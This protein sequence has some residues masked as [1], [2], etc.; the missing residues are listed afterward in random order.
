MLTSS[1]IQ[2]VVLTAS[3]VVIGTAPLLGDGVAI[4]PE[5]MAAY[6]ATLLAASLAV[7]GFLL[8]LAWRRFRWWSLPLD[9]LIL[10]VALFLVGQTVDDCLSQ[11]APS[12]REGFRYRGGFGLCTTNVKGT[13]PGKGSGE[14]LYL[15][16]TSCIPDGA[17]AP[18]TYLRRGNCPLM[19]RVK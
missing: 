2:L 5:Y 7:V 18:V 1:K 15:L 3:M 10:A 12:P 11:L 8:H 19:W 13:L 6:N 9:A 4:V 14:R 17:G 16:V